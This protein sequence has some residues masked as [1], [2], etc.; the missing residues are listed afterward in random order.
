MLLFWDWGL[1]EYQTAYQKQLEACRF[2]SRSKDISGIII[3]CQHPHVVT[4]GSKTQPGDLTTWQGPTIH[5]ARGGRAT[6]HGPSQLV[7]YPIL[8]LDG[9]IVNLPNR[10]VDRHLR[11]LELTTTDVLG[12]QG[13]SATGKRPEL[14]TGVWVDT[15]KIA[16]IGV[17]IKRWISYHGIALNVFHDPNAFQGIKPCGFS[18]DT[19]TSLEQVHP[20]F[21]KKNEDGKYLTDLKMAYKNSFLKRLN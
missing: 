9:S 14:D 12:E 3:F 6:Y 15:K 1:I 20:N 13:I 19:M 10:D 2:V 8:K 4:L 5:V 16:S 11:L 18:P 17:G 7:I 21:S